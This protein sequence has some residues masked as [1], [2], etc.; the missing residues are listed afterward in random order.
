MRLPWVHL[1][2]Q[3]MDM[4]TLE[5]SMIDPRKQLIFEW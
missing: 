2:Y 4:Y 3:M 1:L 5:G